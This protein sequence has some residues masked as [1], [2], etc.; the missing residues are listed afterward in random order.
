MAVPELKVR[1]L[2]AELL[3]APERM[4]S[5]DKLVDDLWGD[6][7]PGDPVGAV[8]TRVSRLRRALVAGGGDRELVAFLA[9][10]YVLRVDADAV[11]S[12]RFTALAVR[13]RAVED[14]RHRAALLS[15]A[16]GLWRGP[17][18]ADFR[19]EPFTREAV[20]RLEELRPAVLEDQAET[21]LE[22]GAHVSVAAELAG[23]VARHPVRE[24][25]RAAQMR[26][27]YR[28]GRSS[29]ALK[30]YNSLRRL[31]ADELGLDPGPEL[32]GLYEEILRHALRASGRRPPTNVPAPAT[33]LIGR[34]EAVDGIR[35][36]PSVGRLVT[37]TG[38]GNDQQP[39]ARRRLLVVPVRSR[40]R[41][42]LSP[43]DAMSPSVAAVPSAHAPR[44][45]APARSEGRQRARSPERRGAPSE[46]GCAA[47]PAV[48]RI[49]PGE[50]AWPSR[51]RC[52]AGT[53][54]TCSRRSASGHA[55]RP[56]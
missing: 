39:L 37:L 5:A 26:A 55:L 49:R 23:L 18:F 35:S 4:V 52:S 48:L 10:G 31:L 40:A 53:F 24:R 29:E 45:R 21:Q 36:L 28:T 20:T 3:T 42:P 34:E 46:S 51:L 30:S 43:S 32:A 50:H 54:A 6:R 16:L 14:P 12:E 44:R 1:A 33:E 2:L 8:Q 25:L 15:D 41:K 13:A 27:L 17:A 19:D 7:P 38:P 22:L 11:D 56:A 9:A 47:R